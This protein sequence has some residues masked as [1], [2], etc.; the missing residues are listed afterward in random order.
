MELRLADEQDWAGCAALPTSVQSTHVWQL[1]VVRDA[2]QPLTSAEINVALRSLRLPRPVT[3]QPAGPSLETLWPAAAAI[4][5]AERDDQIAG[6]IVLTALPERPA[7]AVSRFVVAPTVRERGLASLLLRS[8]VR[9]ASYQQY[10]ALVANCSARN[11]PAVVCLTRNG[12]TFAGY[13]EAMYPR[14][15]VALLW[16]RSA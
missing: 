7:L 10:T 16:Q 6:Y 5:V 14:G 4:L 11:H 2:T 1:S 9:L 3:V 15:E 13:S 8:A 12:F